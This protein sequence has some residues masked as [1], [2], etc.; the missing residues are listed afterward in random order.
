MAKKSLQSLSIFLKGVSMGVADII[1]GVSGGTVAFISGIY[2]ELVHSLGQIDIL[3]VRD[4]YYLC[5][6]FANQNKRKEAKKNLLQ[7]NWFFLVPL[8]LGITGAILIMSKIV[9][10]LLKAYPESCFAFFFG[11]ILFSIPPLLKEIKLNIQS[12]F[13]ILLF[14][15][16]MLLIVN[17]STNLTGSIYLPYVF[18]SGALG[19]CAM[20]LPGISGSYILIILGEYNIILEALNERNLPVV[21]TFILGMG[22]GIYS[23]L[24]VLRYLLDK[25]RSATM[26][27]MVGIMIGGLKKIW[28]Y[29]YASSEHVATEMHIQIVI[30]ILLGAVIAY[31][32]NGVREKTT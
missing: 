30:L 9:P 27:S 10:R 8:F 6:P 4:V 2:N 21:L 13:L 12:I 20:I 24:R 7:I 18:M 32:L 29:S 16:F 14:A 3:N 15:M 19:I 25:H 31:S 28:P 1:P 5:N 22:V 17:S 26:A 11:L 23:F